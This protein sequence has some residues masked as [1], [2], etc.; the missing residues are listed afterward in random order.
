MFRLALIMSL[1]LGLA[2]VIVAENDEAIAP[3]LSGLGDYHYDVTT[4]SEDAQAFFD[5]GPPVDV[6]LQPC[7]G[8][9][10][11][12]GGVA[13]RSEL[14]HGVLGTSAGARAQHQRPHA[15]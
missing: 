11:F 14:R 2:V 6:R 9:P 10:G 5:Q 3:K 7:R 4:S 8:Y 15:S 1:V 12:S 13:T